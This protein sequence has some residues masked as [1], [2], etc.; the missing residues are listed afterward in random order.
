[1]P[2][3]NSSGRAAAL[4][5]ALMLN[6]VARFLER[7]GPFTDGQAGSMV[8][9]F[10]HAC[11]FTDVAEIDRTNWTEVRGRLWTKALA[12]PE[13]LRLTLLHGSESLAE[14]PRLLWLWLRS[15]P[16]SFFPAV[17]RLMLAQIL[18]EAH[19]YDA[20]GES[21]LTADY[22]TSLERL[23]AGAP[24]SFWR[25][26]APPTVAPKL[27]LTRSQRRAYDQLVARATAYFNGV[28]ANLAIKPRLNSFLVAPT[29]AGKST[30]ARLV[31]ERFGAGL[32][33]VSA[34]EWIPQGVHSQKPTLLHLLRTIRRHE[35][36]ILFL[37]EVDKLVETRET[38]WSRS[39]AADIWAVLD[40]RIPV[41]AF[42]T[43]ES[44]DDN[45]RTT[46]TD[47]AEHGLH[48][49]AAGTF[50]DAFTRRR[51]RL[52]GFDA[53]A[54]SAGLQTE[55]EGILQGSYVPEELLSRCGGAE[56]IVIAYPDPEETEELLRASGLQDLAS[57]VGRRL[58]AAD[59]KWEG[60]GW[61]SLEVI[62]ADL[63]VRI[64][65]L[66]RGPTQETTAAA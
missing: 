4:S 8:L 23:R 40:R 36:T 32:F 48:F 61:R 56:P 58:S 49:I 45:D 26:P 47:R 28:G 9:P 5:A 20:E 50:Q 29:G 25:T 64:A 66:E 11:G 46:L 13:T 19:E 10:V 35:R 33:T 62:A 12:D 21:W 60:Q 37:D 16:N 44:W 18:F 22:R 65:D 27:W 1:M 63:M 24:P 6:A 34:G 31:A 3:R 54:G 39:C 7:P 14:R 41:D 51:R 43:A 15:A 57:R 59:V 52:I 53:A 17:E 30:L 42:A 2:A 55:T 38:A